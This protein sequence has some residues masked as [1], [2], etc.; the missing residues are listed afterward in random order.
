VR[1]VGEVIRP[2]LPILPMPLMETQDT[3]R[4]RGRLTV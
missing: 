1:A 2:M 4:N 3:T